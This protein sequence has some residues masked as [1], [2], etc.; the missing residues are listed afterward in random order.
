MKKVL[1]DLLSAPIE[2]TTDTMSPLHC[3]ELITERQFFLQD[4]TP[5]QRD[6]THPGSFL[7]LVDCLI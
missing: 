7:H 2:E 1:H 6:K 4:E 3:V 5:V